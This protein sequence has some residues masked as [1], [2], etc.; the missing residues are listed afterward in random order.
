MW[1]DMQMN[2][3]EFI[4]EH[5]IP[6]MKNTRAI[7]ILKPWIDVG[8]VGSLT[9]V[10]LE[11]MLGAKEF[12]KFRKPGKYFDFTRIRP[13]T[14]QEKDNKVFDIPNCVI[15]HAKD[16]EK[17]IDYLFLHLTEP[18][19]NSEEFCESI[20]DLLKS[21][22]V[23]EYCRIGGFYDAVPHSRPLIV[24]GN[25]TDEQIQKTNGFVSKNISEYQGPT[26]IV[27]LV[28]QELEKVDGVDV[29]SLMVHLP[30][31]VQFE[32]DH[33]GTFRLSQAA[34]KMFDLEYGLS[35]ET[36]GQE[37]YKYIEQLMENNP[38]ASK[39]II[40]KLEKQY[41]GKYDGDL[42]EDFKINNL[43]LMPDIEKFLREVGNRL[44]ENSFE[45]K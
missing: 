45:D 3:N 24:T 13:Y 37:Q 27:N 26:S 40:G 17:D 30:Q 36:K 42:N 4:L 5:P 11:E 10:K 1:Q 25:L 19:N 18:H 29:T 38:N 20:V 14:R 8:R 12:S 22:N 33:L 21:L 16:V 31:Y 32:Q 34:C 35:D 15:N 23:K 41:D 43:P 39:D 6:E 44:D 7:A 9:L 28:S 2:I